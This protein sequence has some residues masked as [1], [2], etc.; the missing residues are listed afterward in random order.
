LYLEY[1]ILPCDLQ[2]LILPPTWEKDALM[3]YEYHVRNQD[4]VGYDWSKQQPNKFHK[5]NIH[6]LI[7]WWDACLEKVSKE[8]A[9]VQE[10]EG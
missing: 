7:P 1:F 8:P 3:G 2:D 10:R 6:R 9:N 5:D 4:E